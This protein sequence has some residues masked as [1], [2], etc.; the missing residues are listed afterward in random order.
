[1]SDAV[2]SAE[3]LKVR[4]G[5]TAFVEKVTK[6]WST[7]AV[8][9]ELM[10]LREYTSQEM[11]NTLKEVGVFKVDSLSDLTYFAPESTE[12]LQKW[13]LLTSTGEFIL[14]GRYIVPIR[15]ICSDVTALVGWYP[16][17]RK[18]ITTPSFGFTRDAQFFNIECFES[19]M[20]NDGGTVFLVEGIFDT[21][22]LR[23]LKFSALGNMGLDLSAI[24]VQI[25]KRFG[26][27]IAI[28]D[29]DTAGK[30]VN[31]YCN[32]FTN[33]SKRS[34]WNIENEVVFVGLPAGVKDVDDFIKYFDCYDDLLSCKDS[35][36]FKKLKE[37]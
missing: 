8:I 18:Y 16:D 2:S 22:A 29:N 25:L 7:D 24:K 6:C 27:V 3:I 11:F 9:T 36:Y 19:C 10:D 14:K 20:K 12:N 1:M 13:G 33:K 21:L 5:F 34:P 35:R 23:S 37:D 28:P 32:R 4:E 17:N 15:D 31:P 30:S 26:K